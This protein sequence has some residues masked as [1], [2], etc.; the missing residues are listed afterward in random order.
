MSGAT[1]LLHGLRV[2][3]ELPLDAPSGDGDNRDITVALGRPRQVPDLG[4]GPGELAAVRAEGRTFSSLR[5][6]ADGFV[7]AYPGL[8]EAH[9]D[10]ALSSIEVRA[11]PRGD[12][13]LVPVVVAGGAMAC[14]LTLAGRLVL[15]A[16][17]V[18]VAGRAVAVLGVSGAGKSVLA[19]AA[20]AAG[21]RHLSDDVLRVEAESGRVWCF[22][23]GRSI[24]LRPDAAGLTRHG[25]LA[26]AASS[27]SADGRICVA[28]P[29]SSEPRPELHAAVVARRTSAPS[30]L[31]RL[32]GGPAT[33]ALLSNP[34]L[35]GLSGGYLAGSHLAAC[36]AVS[37]A[38]PVFEVSLPLEGDPVE[39]A[40][41]L[42]SDLGLAM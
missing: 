34:R 15:H 3:S 25:G 32:E 20:C 14:V 1:Y 23:G 9:I 13:G 31:R 6:C 19:A 21:A 30:R 28:P 41:A 40:S 22:P 5:A 7:L 37:R 27:H 33:V 29:P 4:P 8:L 16:S 17:A 35:A 42:L 26:T 24:R 12:N 2:R 36:A 11:D 10:P 18:E 39:G 38:V